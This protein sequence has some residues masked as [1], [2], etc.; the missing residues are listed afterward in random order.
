MTTF[1]LME[2]RLNGWS[3]IIH[4]EDR[5]VAQQAYSSAMQTSKGY[6]EPLEM[7]VVDVTK[8]G[9]GY[10]L[11]V[12]IHFL[13]H[14]LLPDATPLRS[15]TISSLSFRPMR[16]ARFS[17]GWVYGLTCPLCADCS[18]SPSRPNVHTPRKLNGT[19]SCKS[20][21]LTSHAT[22]S[23]ILSMPYTTAPLCSARAYP[24]LR[25]AW[26]PYGATRRGRRAQS[27]S[28]SMPSS[29]KISIARTR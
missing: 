21:S 1:G 11:D 23:G 17:A 13:R 29:R 16:P 18:G 15:F 7:R 6:S 25:P 28:K 4:P 27:L 9:E 5:P 10:Y 14:F 19:A 22:S 20:N 12:C 2:D 3:N 8:E 24:A 26:A